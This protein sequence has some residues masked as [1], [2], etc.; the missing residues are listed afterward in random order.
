MHVPSLKRRAGCRAIGSFGEGVI[1]RPSHRPLA[2][3][4]WRP[5]NGQLWTSDRLMLNYST[6]L[7]CL[8]G[9]PTANCDCDC[10]C[11][12]GTGCLLWQV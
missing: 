1:S 6:C 9:L 11:D 10:D 5:K 8:L 7:M 2:I 3:W 12:H 4:G